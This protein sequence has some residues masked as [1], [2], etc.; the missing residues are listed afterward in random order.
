MSKIPAPI[1]HE[2]DALRQRAGT[3]DADDALILE[4][5]VNILS[6]K[7]QRDQLTAQLEDQRSDLTE[8]ISKKAEECNQLKAQVG[9]LH[10]ALD[11]N[12]GRTDISDGTISRRYPH[13]VADLLEETR[14]QSL[15][16]NNA[17][18]LEEYAKALPAVASNCADDH[19][20]GMDAM[21]CSEWMIQEA[22]A[23]RQQAKE[24]KS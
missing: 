19:Q 17:D 7:V 15:L 21:D 13:W 3:Y 1:Q 22:N 8:A 18:V 5:G 10:S 16:L 6:L 11:E 9:R 2:M 4:A 12:H 20:Y 23:L 24:N 14:A